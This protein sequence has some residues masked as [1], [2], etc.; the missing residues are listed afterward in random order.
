MRGDWVSAH[1]ISGSRPAVAMRLRQLVRCVCE[2][3]RDDETVG[4]KLEKLL[5][6][7]PRDRRLLLAKRA[8]SSRPREWVVEIRPLRKGEIFCAV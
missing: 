4:A 3:D 8:R 2:V 1:S 6:L 7:G 5:R